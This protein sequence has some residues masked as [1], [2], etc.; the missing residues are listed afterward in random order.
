MER[1]STYY[2][3]A[4]RNGFEEPIR[5]GTREYLEIERSKLEK[6]AN[7]LNLATEN[8]LPDTRVQYYVVLKRDW[9]IEHCPLKPIDYS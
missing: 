5:E 7:A 6:E 1:A 9:D 4:N 3:I 8:R 2:L